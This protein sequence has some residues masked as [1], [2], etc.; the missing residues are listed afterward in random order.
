MQIRYAL[1]TKTIPEWNNKHKRLYTCTIGYSHE[2]GLIRLYPMPINGGNS[3]YLYVCEVRKR[4]TDSRKE[5]YELI[6]DMHELRPFK[7]DNLNKILIENY[8]EPSID[9]LNSDRK[10][11]GILKLDNCNAQWQ[12]EER[13]LLNGQVGMFEDV[14]LADFTNYTKESHSKSARMI[15]KD[16]DGLHNLQYNAWDV[17]EYARKFGHDKDAFRFVKNASHLIVGNMLSH[18]NK[19]L[20]LKAFRVKEFAMT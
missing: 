18:R 3:G 10:S 15:F 14:Q 20:A 2:L 4:K 19:W 11:I 9:S 1:L 5:S 7:K 6:G 17:Y 16:A 13:F 8:V 12:T